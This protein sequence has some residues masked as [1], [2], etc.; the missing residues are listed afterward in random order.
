M[1][2]RERSWALKNTLGA[3]SGTVNRNCQNPKGLGAFVCLFGVLIILCYLYG[4]I[5]CRFVYV[6]TG[7]TDSCELPC[8]RWE[9]SPAPL[10][11]QPVQLT[12]ESSP[13]PQKGFFD[14]CFVLS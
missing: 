1:D 10:E 8:S 14:F 7:V 6:Q 2:R 11:E 5:V 12:A 4:C 9:S 13:A 3:H